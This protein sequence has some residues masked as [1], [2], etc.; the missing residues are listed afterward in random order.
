MKGSTAAGA[1][2]AAVPVQFK[3]R[4]SLIMHA[5]TSC[6]AGQFRTPNTIG[7]TSAACSGPCVTVNDCNW[8]RTNVR[9]HGPSDSAVIR[10]EGLP[11]CTVQLH[12][13]HLNGCDACPTDAFGDPCGLPT[14]VCS[15]LSRQPHAPGQR[16]PLGNHE[17]RGGK[18]P[19]T[20]FACTP[21]LHMCMDRLHRHYLPIPY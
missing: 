4:H 12:H 18:L 21:L 14:A 17:R 6:P 1:S 8:D 19:G 15:G 10:S 2:A 3:L 7:L 13:L 9:R 16:V 11:Q 20:P 5:V